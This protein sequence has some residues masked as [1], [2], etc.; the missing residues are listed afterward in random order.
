MNIDLKPLKFNLKPTVISQLHKCQEEDNEFLRAVLK[1]DIG[2]SIEEF[3][4]KITSS[5]NA[6]RLLGVPLEMIVSGQADHYKK[7]IERGWDFENEDNKES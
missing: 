7:L 1:G 2:N 4:D 5:L 6:L 3:Y